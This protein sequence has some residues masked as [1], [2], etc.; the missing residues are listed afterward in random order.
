MPAYEAPG[1]NHTRASPDGIRC[2]LET[3][4]RLHLDAELQEGGTNLGPRATGIVACTAPTRQRVYRLQ[5]PLAVLSAFTRR[6]PAGEPVT[7]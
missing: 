7:A 6:A 2:R 1:T 4:A 3:R 5:R